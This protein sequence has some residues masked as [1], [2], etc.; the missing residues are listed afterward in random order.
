LHSP[1]CLSTLFAAA[2]PSPNSHRPTAPGSLT[3]SKGGPP[4][5]I[6]KVW[7]SIRTNGHGRAGTR[8]LVSPKGPRCD[9]TS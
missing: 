7:S 8:P 1:H 9:Q 5:R 3:R 6:S 4:L 2:D